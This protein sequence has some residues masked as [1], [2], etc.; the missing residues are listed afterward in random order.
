[1]RMPRIREIVYMHCTCDVHALYVIR[2][3]QAADFRPE[4]SVHHSSSLPTLASSS[5]RH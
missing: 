4:K 1:M 5:G 2:F 3:R